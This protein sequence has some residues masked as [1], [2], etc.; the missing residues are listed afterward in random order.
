[1]ARVLIVEDEAAIREVLANIVEELG[2]TVIL[3]ANGRQAW[4]LL[5]NGMQHIPALVITDNMMPLMNGTELI[6]K[7]RVTPHLRHIP[8]ILMSAGTY[9]PATEAG[10]CFFSKPFD[11]DNLMDVIVQ[12]IG[13][14]HDHH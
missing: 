9:N 10:I 5:S 8:I 1:M 4:S 13:A 2:H 3:A 12:S 14:N 6:Q 7:I 11:L